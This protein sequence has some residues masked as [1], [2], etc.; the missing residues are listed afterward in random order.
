M[1]LFL[2]TLAWLAG[3]VQFA[4]SFQQVRRANPAERIP[5]FFG[6]PRHHPT[7]IYVYR[8]I[9]IVL[10]LMAFTAWAEVIGMW[11]VLLILMAAIP[12]A[13]LN[14]QHNRRVQAESPEINGL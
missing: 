14:I 6:R 13:V 9:A 5:Q 8:A 1:D 10:L 7:E 3:T 4:L 2:G 12:A 11:A